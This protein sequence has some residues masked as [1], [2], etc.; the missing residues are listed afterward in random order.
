MNGSI[1]PAPP[2]T[3]ADMEELK[4]V[5]SL[6]QAGRVS[7]SDLV[8][9][10]SSYPARLPN[11]T[12]SPAEEHLAACLRAHL[13]VNHGHDPNF[14][15]VVDTL[16]THLFYRALKLLPASFKACIREAKSSA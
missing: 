5:C 1:L 11:W 8:A 9:L 10:H 7:W 2:V 16:I 4:S 12:N 6:I 14:Q 15:R 3:P 13:M